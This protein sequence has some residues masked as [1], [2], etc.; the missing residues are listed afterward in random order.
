MKI[1]N[2]N[3]LLNSNEINKFLIKN[4]PNLILEM[5]SKQFIESYITLYIKNLLKE[6]FLLVKHRKGKVLQAR[7]LKTSLLKNS[8]K[9]NELANIFEKLIKKNKNF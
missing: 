9:T 4:H 5:R 8:L 1:K 3:K 6:S 2:K 7:D